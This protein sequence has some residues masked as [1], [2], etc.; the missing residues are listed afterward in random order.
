MITRRRL[1]RGVA[2]TAATGTGFVGYARWWEPHWIAIERHML[3]IAGLPDGLVGA[4]LVQISDLHVSPVV[5]S[6]YLRRALRAVN[7]LAPDILVMTGDW[8][9]HTAPEVVDILARV[10]A[11]LRPA[12]LGSVAILGNH[13][14]GMGWS[15]PDVADA[16]AEVVAA[17]GM[18][19]LRNAH[20]T[21]EGLQLIGIDDWWAGRFRPEEAWSGADL[22]APTLVLSHN[23]DSLDQPG[24]PAYTG[25]VLAGHTHGGQCKPPFL[26]PPILPVVNRRYTSGHIALADGRQLYINRGLGHL[27]PVRFNARPE[28]TVFTL[29]R[30]QG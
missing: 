25:W 2:G 23:P 13:D 20:V 3:P 1:L 26:P 16:V 24:W 10:L 17:A 11:A 28:I 14:Y 19:V 18:T 22:S 12:R 27:M 9:T 30:A 5:D 8:I 4:R 21:V 6:D 7:G 29:E 15:Q